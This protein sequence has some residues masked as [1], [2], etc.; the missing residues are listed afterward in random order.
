MI[1]TYTSVKYGHGEVSQI[2]KSPRMPAATIPG[3]QLPAPEAFSRP[4]NGSNSF[5]PFEMLKIVDMEDLYDTKLPKIPGVLSSHDIYQEDWKRCMQ[6]SNSCM[7]L[8]SIQ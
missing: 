4:I 5:T 8:F 7:Y 6:V 2:G 1:F 3:E